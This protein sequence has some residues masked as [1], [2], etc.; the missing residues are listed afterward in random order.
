M[1]A[2]PWSRGDCSINGQVLD[3]QRPP[4]HKMRGGVN[5]IH[6]VVADFGH[7]VHDTLTVKPP[8]QKHCDIFTTR[9]ER[10]LWGAAGGVGGFI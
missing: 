10:F 1:A 9:L 8:F 5:F 6:F 3:H 4:P 7:L 2:V